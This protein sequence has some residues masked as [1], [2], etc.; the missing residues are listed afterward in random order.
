[1]SAA[2]VPPADVPFERL[3]PAVRQ[4]LSP[5]PAGVVQDV[6][7]HPA[8]ALLAAGCSRW[9]MLRSMTIGQSNDLPLNVSSTSWSATI[10]QSDEHGRF[11]GV[12][13]GEQQLDRRHAVDLPQQ[14]DEKQRR[15]GQAAGFQVRARSCGR[16]ARRRRRRIRAP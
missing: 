11:L 9:R 2:R 14:A 5:A 3:Q 12:I 13:A 15:A 6:D 4:L 7:V 10:C 1:M 8:F 16:E